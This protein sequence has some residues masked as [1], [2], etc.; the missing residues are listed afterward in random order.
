MRHY[1]WIL[2]IINNPFE[3]ALLLKDKQMLVRILKFVFVF[4]SLL[5]IIML[6]DLESVQ[7]CLGL[8]LRNFAHILL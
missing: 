1:V 4:L 8:L 6:G 2:A 3:V 5:Q 7:Q